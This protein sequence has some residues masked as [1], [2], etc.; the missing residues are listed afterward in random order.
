M[1]AA[2]YSS[3]GSPDVIQIMDVEKPVPKPNEVLLK[4]R[5]ASVNPLDWHFLRGLPYPVRLMTGLG[6]PKM[7]G[8]GVDVAGVVE[9]V[10]ANVTQIEAHDPVFGSCRG[11]FAEYACAPDSALVRKPDNITFEQ[12]ASVPVASYTSLQCLRDKGQIQPGHKVLI[13]GA[14][15]GVGTFALQIAKSFG[16]EVTGVCSTR[17][18]ELVR[19]LGADHTIDYTREDFTQNAQRYDMLLDLIGN[20]SLSAIRR[21]LN[22]RGICVTAGSEAGNWMLDSI[23]RSLQA[24][25]L[26]QMTSQKFAGCL[27]KANQADLLVMQG[28]L[29]TGKVIPVIDRRYSLSEVPAAIRYLEAGHARGK[30]IIVL[31]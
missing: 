30:V 24:L 11:A 29:R 6:K 3:Y 28:L 10:G 8:L 21:V 14:A 12:A 15:G 20:H 23:A 7:T 16:A 5:A 27:A 22:P 13:N 19:T 18:V 25:L 17:N 4:V 26:S 1:K 9:S 2:I 31:E